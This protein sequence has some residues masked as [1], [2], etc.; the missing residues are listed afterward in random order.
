MTLI[1]HP[2]VETPPA[3]SPTP[4]E[5]VARA[6]A[7]RVTSRLLAEGR[8][9]A[10]AVGG[11]EARRRVASVVDEVLDAMA[12]DAL[13]Q[14]RAPLDAA[15]EQQ[16]RTLAVARICGMGGLEPLLAEP[17]AHNIL[18]TGEKV[19]VDFG[20]GRR[21]PRPPVAA[22]DAELAALVRRIAASSPS[23]ERRFDA[24]SPLLS[25]ELPDGS[26]LSAVME[27]SR[28]VSVAIRHPRH[29]LDL[30]ALQSSDMLD[31]LARG[32]LEAAASARMNLLISGATGAGKTTLLRALAVA[33]VAPWERVVTVEDSLEL[34]L[35][36][37]LE[38]RC[39]CVALQARPANVEGV[40][41]ITLAELVRHALRLSPDRVI[42]GET[43]GPE[44]IA[45][46]NAMSM[47]TDGSMATI[48]AGSS[49]QVFTKIAAYTAQAPERLSLEA[50]N[51]LA[52]SAVHLVAHI[53]VD[54]RGR[55][56][57]S[58]IR[59]VVGAEGAHVVSNEVYHRPRPQEAGRLLGAPSSERADVL[60]AHGFDAAAAFST[61][62]AW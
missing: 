54:P 26:R 42:V 15:Q 51:L 3:P 22:D 13:A 7:E 61:G 19:I 11:E 32:L 4:V 35:D 45:L 47:G 48:H 58:S 6:V 56:W 16:V 33:A 53:A 41:E 24:S 39:D 27:V 20:G 38:A 46:L 31:G 49:A 23:G 29:A 25:M 10:G 34:N 1:P 18:I 2:S 17:G 62:G 59:E 57:V 12:A 50:A 55:R 30:N 44:T 36:R 5:A 37:S 14:G 21:E 40:G 28:R 60:T 43:R 52:A 9:E 8:L